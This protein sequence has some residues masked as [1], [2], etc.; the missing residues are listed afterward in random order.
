M[1]CPLLRR[2]HPANCRGVSSGAEPLPRDVFATYCRA[3]WGNCPGYRYVR[4]AGH[5]M[6]PAD[7]RSWVVRG[8]IPGRIDMDSSPEPDAA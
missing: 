4:A 5:L 6:H 3:G 8:V 7:F 2:T 1:M